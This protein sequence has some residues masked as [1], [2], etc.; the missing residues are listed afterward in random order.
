MEQ[1]AI[2]FREYHNFHHAI[3]TYLSQ[4]LAIIAL[5][6]AGPLL[7]IILLSNSVSKRVALVTGHLTFGKYRHV[8]C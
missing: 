1:N 4:H 8:S 2:I 3:L 6:T 7:L 5:S